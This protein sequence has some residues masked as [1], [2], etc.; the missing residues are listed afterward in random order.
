MDVSFDAVRIGNIRKERISEMILK[1]NYDLL[2]NNIR[3]FLGEEQFEHE[4]NTVHMVIIIPGKGDKITIHLP[5]IKDLRI[6]KLL[7]EKYHNYI[8]KGKD[9]TIHDNINNRLFR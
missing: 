3:D 5:S 1:Q 2:K 7:K 8:Y 9:D 6:R 4:S